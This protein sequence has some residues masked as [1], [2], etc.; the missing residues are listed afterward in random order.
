M[1]NWS[2]YLKLWQKK[3]N[4]MQV[5]DDADKGWQHMRSL[6][7]EHMPEGDGTAKK[8]GISL[9]SVMLI[10]LS[11]AAMLYVGAKVVE[12]RMQQQH[13]KHYLSHHKHKGSGTGIDTAANTDSVI[14]LEDSVT[15]KAKLSDTAGDIKIAAISSA[16]HDKPNTAIAGKAAPGTAQKET[17]TN[18]PGSENKNDAAANR[19]NSGLMNNQAS[20]KTPV[21]DR[22][23]T[24]NNNKANPINQVQ[25]NGTTSQGNSNTGI[26]TLNPAGQSINQS[27]QALLLGQAR[28]SFNV[29][30]WTISNSPVFTPVTLQN[31]FI[32][33]VKDPNG[34]IIGQAKFVKVN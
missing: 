24:A 34:K 21:G 5:N 8:R 28:Q 20:N 32:T 9:L 3:R 10:T 31:A 13:Q 25:S 30:T 33:P 12:K 26:G 7:D 14:T 15:N 16:E 2:Q 19:R 4:E 27:N 6:L 11:A 23:H 1:K 17:A 18:I 22:H 29:G